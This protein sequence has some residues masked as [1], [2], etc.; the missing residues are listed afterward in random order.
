MSVLCVEQNGQAAVE[1]SID[2]HCE[3]TGR[4]ILAAQTSLKPIVHCTDCMD[5]P[6]GVTASANSPKIADEMV[7]PQIGA[8]ITALL[9][10]TEYPNHSRLGLRQALVEQHELRSAYIGQRPN[11][12]IQQ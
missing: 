1:Y 6:L 2:A 4:S 9:A 8:Y 7:V 5:I 11:I 12:V 3:D 10:V